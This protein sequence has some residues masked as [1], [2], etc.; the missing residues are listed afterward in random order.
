MEGSN[1]CEFDVSVVE[2][3]NTA[4][5][6]GGVIEVVTVGFHFQFSEPDFHHNLYFSAIF[7]DEF[8][9][10]EYEVDDVFPEN[11]SLEGSR[12]VGV[13][14][15]PLSDDFG[16]RGDIF[17]GDFSDG[18]PIVLDTNGLGV[19]SLSTNPEQGSYR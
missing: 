7:E 11:G 5:T 6:S 17:H 1:L 18:I 9:G 2:F 8:H 19:H 15:E 10:S 12:A 13:L 16:V 14:T 3:S 4:N